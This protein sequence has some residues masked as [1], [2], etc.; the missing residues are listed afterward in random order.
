MRYTK[1]EIARI[2]A[3]RALQLASGAQPLVKAKLT[4]P[5]KVA[6]LEFEKGLIPLKV[7]RRIQE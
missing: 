6:K 4:D 3:A 2:I 1:Y 7:K 5:I